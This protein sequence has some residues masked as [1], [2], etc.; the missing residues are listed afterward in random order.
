VLPKNSH[1]E[2]YWQVEHSGKYVAFN[3][4]SASTPYV[5]GIVAL[6][7][8]KK[9]N[10]TVREIKDLLRRHASSDVETTGAVP[11]PLWGYGKLDIAA[12]KAILNDVN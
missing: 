6:M 2:P 12:V 8:Q 5:A 1:G 7:M 11:N 3:G 9:P 4:T 10:I